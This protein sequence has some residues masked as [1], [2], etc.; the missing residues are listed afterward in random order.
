DGGI[1]KTNTGTLRFSGSQSNTYTGETTVIDGTL[2]LAKTGGAIAVPGTLI[3]G[4]NGTSGVNVGRDTDI[5]REVGSNQTADTA[6]ILV[7]STGLLN[8]AGTNEVQQVTVAC[9]TGGTYTLTVPG[10]G[11]TIP[12]L[13]NA[14]AA[15]VQA[16]LEMLVGAG[17]VLVTG[18][19]SAPGGYTVTFVRGMGEQNVPLLTANAQ[20]TITLTGATPG[21]TQF[22][23][24]FNGQPTSPI[25]SNAP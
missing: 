24:T 3:I 19:A 22:T 6:N 20:A 18:A 4:D 12:L 7:T 2:L 15:V 17:N 9:A 1:T 13:F 10:F 25:P 11:T 21:T 5:V 8:T 16:A 14:A 23:L